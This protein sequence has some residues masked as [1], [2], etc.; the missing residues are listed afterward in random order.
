MAAKFKPPA[1][2]DLVDHFTYVIMV[3]A[4]NQE[5][6]S[7]EARPPGRPLGLGKLVALY[8]DT[9]ITIDG[10]N[11]WCPS[12]RKRAQALRGPTAWHV[13]IHVAVATLTD[14][15]AIQPQANRKPAKAVN[16]TGPP[17]SRVTTTIGYGSP[18]KAN[19]AGV[20]G[21]ALGADEGRAHPHGAGVELRQL[22]GAPAG[23]T[24]LARSNQ[25]RAGRRSEWTATWATYRS[26][27]PLKRRVSRDA[28][29]V[30]CPRAGKPNAASF[31][32]S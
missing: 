2:V 5:G 25:P 15:A 23:L 27:Y 9:S 20:H 17:E 12:P 21:A 8:D 1:W 3:T 18:N 31:T 11:R 4:A 26:Q 13:Q 28:G 6:I 16:P 32:P 22:R 14:V 7:S 29:A 30:S 10:D 24:P 19:T